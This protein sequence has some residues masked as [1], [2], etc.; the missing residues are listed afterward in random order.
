MTD[1]NTKRK[2]NAALL[3]ARTTV[4]LLEAELE[5]H[6]RAPANDQ[7]LGVDELLAEYGIGRGTV[8][9][10][11]ANGE[12]TATRGARGKI[13]VSRSEVDRWLRARPYKPGPRR[14]EEPD[15]GDALADALRSGELVRGGRK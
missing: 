7:L 14:V 2:L 5:E 4:A 9:T 3:A 15:D 11:V 13:L 8:Q 6:E 10:A 12:L 1:D